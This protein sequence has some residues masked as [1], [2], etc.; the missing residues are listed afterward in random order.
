[1]TSYERIEQAILYLTDHYAERPSLDMVASHVGLSPFH[2]QRLFQEWA[3]V[4]PKKFLQYMSVE[5]A[6][7]L[8]LENQPILD[9]TFEVG[10]S[11]TG[12]LHDLFVT[13]EAMTPGEFKVGGKGVAINYCFSDTRFGRV[14]SASSEKGV[15]YLAFCADDKEGLGGLKERF[16]QSLLTLSSN[17]IQQSALH[18]LGDDP[19]VSPNIHLNLKGTP[20]Q[21]KVWQALLQLPS[22]SVTT[23]ADIASS[24]GMPKAARAV[25]NAVG[26]NPVAYLIPCHRVI[27]ATGIIG[28]YRW[29]VARKQ[30]MLGWEAVRHNTNSV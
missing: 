22:G 1:M 14:I 28:G 24:I 9:T 26:A 10:L 13:I 15:C 29:G 20:F 18:R 4:S 3:G 16:P 11:S 30:A 12:R 27:R 2:F 23:Y 7:T 8:L 5:H 19:L 21:L 17:A 6:K 25:G